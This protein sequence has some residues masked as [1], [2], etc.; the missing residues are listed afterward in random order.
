M[1]AESEPPGRIGTVARRALTVHG[2]TRHDEFATLIQ[3]DRLRVHDIGPKAIRI[4][5]EELEADAPGIATS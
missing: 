3:Q 1:P 2:H 4:L 5:G